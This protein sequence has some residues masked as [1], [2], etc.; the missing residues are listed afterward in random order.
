MDTPS[1]QPSDSAETPEDFTLR[2]SLNGI[3]PWLVIIYL[4]EIGGVAAEPGVIVGDGWRA[5]VWAGAPFRL[6][7]LTLGV[8]EVALS[9]TAAGRQAVSSAAAAF[10]KKVLRAGG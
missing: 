3:G 1:S 2:Y 10:E 9:G 4:T 5:H 7:A 8:T 6:G